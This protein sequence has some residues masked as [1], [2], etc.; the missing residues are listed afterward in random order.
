MS[1]GAVKSGAS[2]SR[3][4]QLDCFRFLSTCID[5]LLLPSFQL[6]LAYAMG[7]CHVI[8]FFLNEKL[9]P[10]SESEHQGQ[11]PTKLV[12]KA[13]LRNDYKQDVKY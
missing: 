8:P 13:S 7:E 2:S 1:A 11:S 6:L 3:V 10:S 12:V 9:S 4:A 5:P